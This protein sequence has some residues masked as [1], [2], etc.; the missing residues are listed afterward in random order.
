MLRTENRRKLFWPCVIGLLALMGAL[1]CGAASAQEADDLPTLVLPAPDVYLGIVDEPACAEDELG[2][3]YRLK[4]A[5]YP[6]A[7]VESYVRLLM[8]KYGLTRKEPGPIEP[9]TTVHL[10]DADGNVCVDIYWVVIKTGNR[11][12][13]EFADHCATAALEAM[14]PP[15]AVIMESDA[16]WETCG[17]CKGQARCL[18]C[19]GTGKLS[20]YILFTRDCGDCDRGKCRNDL[21]VRGKV[22]VPPDEKKKEN[23]P[24]RLMDEMTERRLA[25][26]LMKEMNVTARAID[27]ATG[28]PI[29]RFDGALAFRSGATSY[30]QTRFLNPIESNIRTQGAHT[31]FTLVCAQR[32]GDWANVE[33]D[34]AEHVDLGDIKINRFDPEQPY[35]RMNTVQHEDGQL[36][37]TVELVNA[38]NIRIARITAEQNGLTDGTMI[39]NGVGGFALKNIEVTDKAATDSSVAFTYDGTFYRLES[40]TV[41]VEF[42][43]GN[44]CIGTIRVENEYPEEGLYLQLNQE[45]K[46]NMRV[47]G[48]NYAISRR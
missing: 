29:D 16:F 23:E 42:F 40:L 41:S 36:T 39:Y 31:R 27:P 38:Q 24:K 26:K 22:Y 5:V 4:I 28:Q 32:N 47:L 34:R 46:P 17:A 18:T 19:S 35:L 2:P 11:L 30:V 7:G 3:D 43:D 44:T 9:D 10:V 15:P 45:F 12:W 21:C 8:E 6:K 13:F 48:Y 14:T 33:F 20:W 25:N 1:T 37:H